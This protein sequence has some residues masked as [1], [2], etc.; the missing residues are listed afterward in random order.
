MTDKQSVTFKADALQWMP[1][2]ATAL[3]WFVTYRDALDDIRSF[4]IYWDFV[5]DDIAAAKQFVSDLEE[6]PVHN[7]AAIASDVTVEIAIAS[8]LADA[9]WDRIETLLN[10]KA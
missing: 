8:T 10:R 6:T 5:L 7:H 1:R 2:T 3:R 4:R 9:M